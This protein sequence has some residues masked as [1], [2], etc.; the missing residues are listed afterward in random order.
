MAVG[1]SGER[2]ISIHTLASPLPYPAAPSSRVRHLPSGE[3]IDAD[4][5][6]FITSME[7]EIRT[8]PTMTERK[9][10]LVKRFEAALTATM[11]DEQAVSIDIDG[12]E[13]P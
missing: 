6:N 13:Y 7:R 4:A 3:I 12:P 9:G 11:L 1:A 2:A 8:E 10:S 5:R